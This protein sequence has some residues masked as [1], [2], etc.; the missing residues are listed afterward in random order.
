M[1]A[2]HVL[3]SLPGLLDGSGVLAQDIL[4]RNRVIT[5]IQTL[6]QTFGSLHPP[7]ER[8]QIAHGVLVLCTYRIHGIKSNNYFAIYPPGRDAKIRH[9][10]PVVP[11]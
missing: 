7:A 8:L 10:L 9:V 3:R 6:R 11:P 2:L 4:E 1:L 5:L